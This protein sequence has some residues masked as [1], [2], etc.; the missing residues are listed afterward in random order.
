V[1]YH[2][3]SHTGVP[4]EVDAVLRLRERFGGRVVGVKDSGGDLE[5]TKA[6]LTVPGLVVLSG[7]DGNVDAAFRAGVHGIVSSLANAVPRAVDAVRGAVAARGD[8]RAEQE[9]LT[10]LRGA[11]KSVPQRSAVK[12]LVAH[13]VGL[14][15]SP[16]RPPLADVTDA[17]SEALRAALAGVGSAAG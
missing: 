12:A 8:G 5:H 10:M 7:T 6:L 15:R 2:I 17:E 13:A 3:P 16:V 9:V 4:I 11:T 14:P 1:L